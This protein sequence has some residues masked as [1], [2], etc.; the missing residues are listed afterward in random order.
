MRPTLRSSDSS[1][2]YWPDSRLH[3]SPT[4]IAASLIIGSN[5]P[6]GLEEGRSLP[7]LDLW[8]NP[9]AQL[10]YNIP[11]QL[12]SFFARDNIQK[13]LED[14]LLRSNTRQ[15]APNSSE[16]IRTFALCGGGGIGKTSIAT[17]FVHTHKDL[18]EAVFWV[19]ADSVTTLFYAY[20]EI[21]FLLGLQDRSKPHDM[22]ASQRR[23]R[24]WLRGW[25]KPHAPKR[26]KIPWLIVFDNVTVPEDLREFWPDEGGGDILITTRCSLLDTNEF[27]GQLGIEVEPFDKHVALDFLRG[28]TNEQLNEADQ[29]VKAT[30]I[31]EMLG[32]LP[33]ALVSLSRL[34]NQGYLG[35][36]GVE[37]FTRRRISLSESAQSRPDFPGAPI[38][39]V[40][41]VVFPLLDKLRHGGTLIQVL[42]LLDPG[43]I[44]EWILTKAASSVKLD[45]FPQSPFAYSQA[46]AE[47]AASSLITGDNQKNQIFVHRMIQDATKRKMTLGRLQEV[48]E[49][50]V[51]LF[52]TLWPDMAISERHNVQRWGKVDLLLRHV[53]KLH[54]I[55]ESLVD[56][57][58]SLQASIT[59]AKVLNNAAWLVFVHQSQR[60]VACCS[61]RAC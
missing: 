14:V 42:S 37:T 40:V 7:A 53:R 20:A 28:L 5:T 60:C 16:H 15:E 38:D 61:R 1:E 51:H 47:L 48:F 22:I 26:E 9:K 52:S 35:Q 56:L 49:A 11:P 44:E 30:E 55:H 34:I 13:S 12:S 39:P 54:Q 27:F 32:G 19:N 2:L 50:T 24:A 29:L 21:A 18:Y 45:G 23:V 3:Q 46:R 31:A 41:Y 4:S 8:N 6:Q 36:A 25:S 33:L 58:L 17:N 59:F 43:G 57:P 10:E